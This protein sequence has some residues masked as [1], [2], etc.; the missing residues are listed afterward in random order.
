M[1]KDSGWGKAPSTDGSVESE[2]MKEFQ[3]DPAAYMEQRAKVLRSSGFQEERQR[4]MDSQREARKD[5]G[6]AILRMF[7]SRTANA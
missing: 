5:R 2:L 4:I 3:E 1:S 6:R 7:S